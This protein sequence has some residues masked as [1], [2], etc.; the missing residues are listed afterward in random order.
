MVK[1]VKKDTH[2]GP[3]TDYI[4]KTD[5]LKEIQE[6]ITFNRLLFKRNKKNAHFRSK[7]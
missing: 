6:N 5:F 4:K 1:V 2:L 7:K 3:K